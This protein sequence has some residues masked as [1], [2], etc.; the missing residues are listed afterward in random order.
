MKRFLFITHLTPRAKRTPLRQSLIGIYEKALLAQSYPHWQVLQIGE[1]EKRSGN[2]VEVQTTAGTREEGFEQLRRI[3]ARPDVRELISAA[4]YIIK[5]DDDDIISPG[6]LEKA[7]QFDFDCY[8]DE[9]HTFYDI[10]SGII[11][12]QQRPWIAST[13]IH[14]K[15]C[16]FD[17]YTGPGASP[18]ENLLYSDHSKAWHTYYAGKKKQ[19]ADPAYPVYL[20]VLSPSS[21]TSSTGNAAPETFRDVAFDRYYAYLKTFGYWKPAAV[22]GFDVYKPLLSGA[23]E[24]F[25]GQKQM[26][27]PGTGFADRVSDRIRSL[28]KKS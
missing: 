8:Y 28:W 11:T 2:F 26:P 12:Q 6:I 27:V 13:C 15:V 19:I 21:I 1:E 17:R 16:A 3:Y 20:R 24:K 9:Q 10:S 5:L 4:D 18:L 22:N 25:S 14:R 23:W 7:A